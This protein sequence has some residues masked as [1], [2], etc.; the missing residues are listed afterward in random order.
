M[1]RSFHSPPSPSEPLYHT[2]ITFSL[3]PLLWCLPDTPGQA[4]LCKDRPC[5]PTCAQQ[6]GHSTC[7]QRCSSSLTTL[8][9]ILLV[10]PSSHCAPFLTRRPP[11]VPAR[12][13]TLI[14]QFPF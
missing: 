10:S 12:I 1:I 3:S 14:Y 13:C 9:S 5:I 7:E 8:V 6:P 2:L 4:G 11:Q